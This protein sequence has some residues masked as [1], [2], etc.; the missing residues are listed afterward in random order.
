MQLTIGRRSRPFQRTAGASGR[1]G[2]FARCDSAPCPAAAGPCGIGRIPRRCF[3][4]QESPTAVPCPPPDP[5]LPAR[6]RP[7]RLRSA[8]FPQDRN[9]AAATK[10]RVVGRDPVLSSRFLQASRNSSR[11][12]A[13]S[14]WRT[15]R[16]LGRFAGMV[17]LR[18]WESCA[19]EGKD[20]EKLTVGQSSGYSRAARRPG[21][22]ISRSFRDDC[23][24]TPDRS[25]AAVHDKASRRPALQGARPRR[26]GPPRERNAGAEMD[27]RRYGRERCRTAPT[28]PATDSAGWSP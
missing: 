28:R 16:T 7:D 22:A 10:I 4:A 26:V 21:R 18:R 25:P 11:R 6:C 12:R 9:Y 17:S 23:R 14:F 2:V 3:A 20:L 8:G 27:R 15:R 13:R 5:R 1:A 19:G 24:D